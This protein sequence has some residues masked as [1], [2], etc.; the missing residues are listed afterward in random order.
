M[1]NTIQSSRFLQIGQIYTRDDLRSAFHIRDAA[2][3]NGIFK[4][5][6]HASVW[7]FV[8]EAKARDRTPYRDKLQG[9]SLIMDGQTLGR[10]DVLIETHRSANLELLLFYRKSKSEFPNAGFR[11]E[12]AFVYV[13]S[14]GRHPSHFMLERVRGDGD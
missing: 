4:P 10:T 13:S 9:D 8:T 5:K 12:G 3:N 6:G 2:L 11:Y 1:D 14:E 7:L